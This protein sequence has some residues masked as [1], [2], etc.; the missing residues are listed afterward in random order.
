MTICISVPC[1]VA[2]GVSVFC[3]VIIGFSVS[4]TMTV[5]VSVSCTVTGGVFDSEICDSVCICGIDCWFLLS[6]SEKL[7]S[8]MVID[9]IFV[10][11]IGTV[12]VRTDSVSMSVTAN[13]KVCVCV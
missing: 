11:T 12:G 13:I 6:L 2:I 7:V 3:T 4:Y 1:T 10:S 8:L 5:G 9:G